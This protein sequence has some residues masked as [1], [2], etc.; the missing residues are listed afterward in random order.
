VMLIHH[1]TGA[2]LAARQDALEIMRLSNV[3]QVHIDQVGA[4][5]PARAVSIVLEKCLEIARGNAARD[6]VPLVRL[7]VLSVALGRD[8]DALSFLGRAEE[9]RTP[10][11][12]YALA[13][14]LFDR[15]RSHPRF[16]DLAARVLDSRS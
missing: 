15:L 3:P 14:P 16:R 12:V 5:E 7:A 8:D 9:L 11:L 4:L 10:S 6:Y 13:D 1:H 2:S